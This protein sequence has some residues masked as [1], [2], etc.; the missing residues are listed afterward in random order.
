MHTKRPEIQ[1]M[2]PSNYPGE[3]SE[4]PALRS[5]GWVAWQ[6]PTPRVISQ[7]LMACWF[8]RPHPCTC[9]A[10][11]VIPVLSG[12]GPGGAIGPGATRSDTNGALWKRQIRHFQVRHQYGWL[13]F[14]EQSLPSLCKLQTGGTDG[15]AGRREGGFPWRAHQAVVAPS[16]I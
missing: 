12:T 15:G 10:T 6:G 4:C 14:L 13:P 3:H 9:I 2:E 7:S 11:V 8:A 16:R 1:G 5:H